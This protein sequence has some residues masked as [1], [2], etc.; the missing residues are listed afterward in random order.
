MLY[1]NQIQID[2]CNVLPEMRDNDKHRFV[3][4]IPIHTLHLRWC[5][6]DNCKFVSTNLQLFKII[7]Y[8]FMEANVEMSKQTRKWQAVSGDLSLQFA[9]SGLKEAKRKKSV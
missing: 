3:V 8:R 2:I 1:K 6:P 5:P 7:C 9:F 4:I